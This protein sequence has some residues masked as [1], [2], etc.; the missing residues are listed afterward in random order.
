[1]DSFSASSLNVFSLSSL[2]RRLLF[3]QYLNCNSSK[4]WL[5]QETKLNSNIKFSINNYNI[6]RND[7]Q[8]GYGG[9]VAIVIHQCIATRNIKLFSQGIEAVSVEAFLNNNWVQLV[10]CYIPPTVNP[11]TCVTSAFSTFLNNNVCL[12][13]GDFNAKDLSFGDQYTNTL[14]MWLLE[15]VFLNQFNIVNPDS[16]TCYRSAHGSYIDKFLT[17][18]M[19][20]QLSCSVL[21]SFSDHHQIYTQPVFTSN[22]VASSIENIKLFSWTSVSKFNKFILNEFN[23]LDVPINRN[24]SVSDID[25]YVNTINNIFSEAINRYVPS[26]PRD[27]NKIKLSA[28]TLAIRQNY[29]SR[30]RHYR[31]NPFLPA[32]VIA[33]LSY[34]LR[35][36][37]KLLLENIKLD[38]SNYY[39]NILANT[40]NVYQF[41]G[42][43]SS[44][45]NSG[46][47]K[48]VNSIID[49]SGNQVQGELNVCKVLAEQFCHNHTLSH[50]QISKHDN[51][52]RNFVNNLSDE[53]FLNFSD[54]FPA[55]PSSENF[56]ENDLRVSTEKV[57]EII[58]SRKNRS[59]VGLDKI[60]N[61]LLKILDIKIIDT[62]VIIFNHIIALGYFPK[63][64]KKALIV[65]IPKAG[66]NLNISANW[67]PISL[68]SCLSK[69]FERIIVER[70]N[71][72]AES[73]R[74]LPDHQFG[75]RAEHSTCHPLALLYNKI[76]SG[77]NDKK[78]T[79]L[80]CLDIKA[81]FD[82][83]WHGALLFKMHKLNFPRY[84]ISIVAKFLLNRSF[85][86][87]LGSTFSESK[88]ILA[89]VPQ[90][91]VLGPILFN[92]FGHDIPKVDGFDILQFA[93]DT[94]IAIT[95]ES[96]RGIE[97]KINDYLALLYNWYY[98]WK[99]I[100]NE[101]KS[102]LI[103]FVGSLKHVGPGRRK[104]A[105]NFNIKINNETILH[106]KT[107]KY[108]GLHF[109][110]NLRFNFHINQILTRF[111]KAKHILGHL[112][113]NQL[114]NVKFK[115]LLYSV[116][117]RP[118]LT[119][120]APIWFNP[121]SISSHQ[122]ERLRL[123]ERK[124]I[125]TVYN[126]HRPRNTF[127]YIS[128]KTLYKIFDYKRL[129][130]H[131]AKLSANFHHA[132]IYKNSPLIKSLTKKY[133]V[134]DSNDN[135]YK[136]SDFIYNL[137]LNNNLFSENG[138]MTLFNKA[139]FQDNTYVYSLDQ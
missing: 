133:T 63:F 122:V 29:K 104:T 81:A 56:T 2:S 28:T 128:N 83:V 36:V 71:N 26:A 51:N 20:S 103:H 110:A 40:N 25:H 72:F 70:I 87:K 48:S 126:I 49:A 17:R 1:M 77:L 3:E 136:R 106:K 90:G 82:T 59:A 53:T 127:R 109:H 18:N 75:F 57:L 8:H 79:T 95:Y 30:L 74:V 88:P 46:R 119:Y 64:W 61:R 38:I 76:S 37:K 52:V 129:D 117:L 92:I 93:D 78:I 132:N 62:L 73:N 84:I 14:G 80:V 6:F 123:V 107:V 9:G 124:T 12:I 111:Q 58:N 35:L 33:K 55:L 65:P 134:S 44:K 23:N 99:L 114:M 125:R 97:R 11:D 108:L 31:R 66:K 54:S 22:N 15:F 130:L 101:S 105:R 43:V 94:A 21:P 19:I 41:H 67:R 116:Y 96:A 47:F 91:S 42:I 112:M 139:A 50:S 4:I 32:S 135:S 113:T 102:E 100:L 118:I 89:G 39:K 7:R 69:V 120:A 27:R 5:L 86:V 68:L 131:L 16:P 137:I 10:S 85:V 13:G 121:S 60:P 98:N 34:E 115:R 138:Q 45:K 24:V